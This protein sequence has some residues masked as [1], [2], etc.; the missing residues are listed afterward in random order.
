MGK[1]S[2]GNKSIEVHSNAILWEW[3]GARAWATHDRAADITYDPDAKLYR[4]E[5]SGFPP[6]HVNNIVN[7]FKGAE[8][9]LDSLKE[10]ER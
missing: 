3:I 1:Q 7:A 10:V 8:E 4:V 5:V 6:V 9:R 2:R